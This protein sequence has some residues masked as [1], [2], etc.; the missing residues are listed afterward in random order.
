M[1]LTTPIKAI[2]DIMRKDVGVD[3]DAQRI[4][5]MDWLIFLKSYDDR[6]QVWDESNPT[7]EIR[8]KPHFCVEH[9]FWGT[10]GLEGWFRTDDKSGLIK[11]KGDKHKV[12]FAKEVV[13]TIDPACFEVFRP[14]FDFI[15]SKCSAGAEGEE[16]A[17]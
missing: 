7:E 16:V 8:P 10:D 13:P 2:Q 12:R 5:Q 4:S 3:G 15:K 1:S 17:S 11:F 9:I 14:M 6:K